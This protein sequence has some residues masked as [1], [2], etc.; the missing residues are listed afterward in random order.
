[1]KKQPRILNFVLVFL[2]G[3]L[4]AAPLFAQDS[5]PAAPGLAQITVTAMSTKSGE[6]APALGKQDVLFRENGKKAQIVDWVPTNT[7]D[8]KLQLIILIDQDTSTRLGSH[9]NEIASF[10]RALP[11]N[12]TV[13]VAYAMNGAADLRTPFT[14]NREEVINSLHITMGAAAG[15][16]S[17]YEALADLIKHW[18]GNAPR[19]EVLLL[20]DGI[21]PTYGFHDTAPWQNPALDHA[22]QA[23]Q[24]AN[25]TIFSI[26]VRAAGLEARSEVL[27]LNGQGS[28]NQLTTDTGG[29]SFFQGSGTAVSFQ[30]FFRDLNAMLSQ[31]YLLTFRPAP[32]KKGDDHQLKVRTEIAHVKLL[33][34]SEIY[35]PATQ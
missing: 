4:F 20:S 27:N 14:A 19:R 5:Q 16:T 33:A 35:L 26:F 29:Y 32:T 18:P 12:S 25:V 21:D 10:I 1:M 30:S 3:L 6:A 15:M 13:A 31:Q 22:T 8:S 34:P 24:N 28:L 9:F 23:A 2:S 11:S 17:I 7:P